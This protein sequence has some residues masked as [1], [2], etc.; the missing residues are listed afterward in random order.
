MLFYSVISALILL[1]S[2]DIVHGFLS[3]P[4][5]VSLLLIFLGI[6]PSFVLVTAF[7]VHMLYLTH[8]PSGTSRFPEFSFAFFIA[9][10]PLA[11]ISPSVNMKNNVILIPILLILIIL[12]SNLSSYFIFLKRKHLQQ[13]LKYFKQKH[14]NLSL[15]LI[16]TSLFFIGYS[17]ILILSLKLFYNTIIDKI[18]VFHNNDIYYLLIFMSIGIILNLLL[19]N[20][21]KILRKWK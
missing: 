1:E 13:V 5:A 4:F 11:D 10:I 2:R 20:K 14:P 7:V 3:Q 15:I 21:F 8:T 16:I 12:I 9:L 6:D 19:T 18:I 17:Y